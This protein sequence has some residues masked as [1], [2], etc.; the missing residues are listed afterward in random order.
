MLFDKLFRILVIG[1]A[2][3]AAFAPAGCASTSQQKPNQT[4]QTKA[5]DEDKTPAQESPQTHRVRMGGGAR[6]W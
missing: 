2:A 1:G 3:A 6:G 5:E 4:A